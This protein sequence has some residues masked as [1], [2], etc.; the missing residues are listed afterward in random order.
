MY[1]RRRI[2]AV[3]RRLAVTSSAIAAV[4]ANGHDLEI[5]FVSGKWYRYRGAALHLAPLMASASK[6][7][8]F[9]AEIKDNYTAIGPY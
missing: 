3:S 9:N 7:T 5:Q 4:R 1:P 2:P 8:Y 6:G